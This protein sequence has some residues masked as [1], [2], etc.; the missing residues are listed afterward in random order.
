MFAWTYQEGNPNLK[1][2][3]ANTWTAGIVF[4]SRAENAWLAGLTGAIDWWKVDLKDAIQQYSIDYARYLCYG[5][6]IVTTPEEAAAQA[7]TEACRN[8]PR[9]LANG[10]ATTMLLKYDNLAT[11]A[12]S[13]V[14]VQL[15]WTAGLSDLGF[16]NLPG[17]VGMNVQ[18]SILDY[19]KTKA[20]PQAFDVETDWKGS[21]GPTL[22]G[23]N[24]G[25]YSYRLNTAFSYTL[26]NMS[27]SLR[28]RHLPSVTTAAAA[29]ERAIVENN[30]RVANGGDGV[31]LS[32]TPTTAIKAK[33]YDI[34]DLS[35]TWNAT[36]HLSLRAGI[37]NLFDRMPVITGAT[38]GYPSGTNLSAV[39]DQA[40]EALGCKDPTSLS[41]PNDGAGTT[42]AGFYDTL[43]RR[44]FLGFKATF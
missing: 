27:F 37:D 14:D 41:Y 6:V 4:T 12:T 21:L 26:P 3:R 39:C 43:G 20:S 33:R 13:G 40:A 1:S 36:E 9:N 5:T 24:P 22:S 16:G 34:F 19:Y 10:A 35:G 7:N 38:A 8:V 32:Y 15:N 29:A 18:A 17:R 25:A 44:Y 31:I 2:E 42:S 28:W 30:E 23:T 11:I